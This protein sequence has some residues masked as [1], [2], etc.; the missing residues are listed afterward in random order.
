MGKIK[1]LDNIT[2]NQIAAG[3]VV[4]RPV[5]VVK[6]L[7]ENSLDAGA[8]IITVTIENG[9]ISLIEVSDN[10]T[11][12]VKEDMELAFHRYATSKLTTVLDFAGIDTMGFRGEALASIASVAKVSMRSKHIMSDEGNEIIVE[13]GRVLSFNPAPAGDG[14]TIRVENLF[15]NTP[16]RYKFLKK[17]ST[18]ASYIKDIVEKLVLAHPHVSFK[19]IN[20]DKEILHS[21]G[22]ND[23]KS[24]VFTVYG[25]DVVEKISPV[26]YSAGDINVSGYA[27]HP[28]LSRRNRNFQVFFVNKRFIK[29]SMLNASLAQAYDT[30]LMKGQ[31]AF[32]VLNISLDPSM[33]DVNVHPQKTQVKFSDDS[34][35]FRAVLH[36]VQNA[37]MPDR[38]RDD[39]ASEI[40][41]LSENDLPGAVSGPSGKS[42]QGIPAWLDADMKGAKPAYPDPG[43]GGASSRPG[44]VGTGRGAHTYGGKTYEREGDLRT[45]DAGTVERERRIDE[46]GTGL[47]YEQTSDLMPP[48]RVV[49]D[50]K[51]S[52][53]GPLPDNMIYIGSA[54]KTYLFFQA[55]ERII[56]IDQHAAHERILFEELL[57]KYSDRRNLSQLLLE[58]VAVDLPAELFGLALERQDVLTGLGFDFEEFGSKTLLLRSVPA[59]EYSPQKSFLDALDALY[60]RPDPGQDQI[61]G[62]L[63]SMACKA[64]VKA[65]DDLK[66]Q[67]VAAL[68]EQMKKTR[69]S[70]H[71]PHGRPVSIEISKYEMEKW[72]KRVV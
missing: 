33:I 43:A 27:G 49:V 72:F 36:G 60:E 3:E 52:N 8:S 21:P 59:L 28:S 41:S 13:A 9:G 26:E 4:E 25:R 16:A 7:C 20:N 39:F 6:E 35:V 68:V 37:L 71:C 57:E 48:A 62:I 22:N 30:L 5:S 38:V 11:G 46:A 55:D 44:S 29:S 64:A 53:L 24:A 10:G 67:E 47:P 14:T 50:D 56:V 51:E 58:P 45:P 18:E 70:G 34:A 2:A 23:L 42:A 1:L 17:D 61:E 32:C 19:L 63:F 54:F 12:I 31:F 40:P 65:N 69:R 15:F 66:P